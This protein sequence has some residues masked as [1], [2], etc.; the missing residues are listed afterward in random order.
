MIDTLHTIITKL[1]YFSKV[2]SLHLKPIQS[3][4]CFCTSLSWRSTKRLTSTL[5]DTGC[6][7]IPNSERGWEGPSGARK[8]LKKKIALPEEDISTTVTKYYY[9]YVAVP[10]LKKL[11]KFKI[12][13][14]QIKA[15]LQKIVLRYYFS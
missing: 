13:L 7:K 5:N 8:I 9:S 14:L 15:I 1:C 10:F 6:L 11:Q 2:K 3:R 12:F 4:R